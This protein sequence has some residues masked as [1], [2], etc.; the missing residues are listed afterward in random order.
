MEDATINHDLPSGGSRIAGVTVSRQQ[1]RI[2]KNLVLHAIYLTFY[3]F[4]KNLP[5][6]LFNYARYLIIRLFGAEIAS[7]YVA[8]GVLIWFPWNV[9]IGR[10]VSLNQGVIIDGLGGVTI[11]DGVR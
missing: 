11:G 1:V 9:C 8:D 5:L 4:V 2:R 3:G 10:R 6:P 7:T